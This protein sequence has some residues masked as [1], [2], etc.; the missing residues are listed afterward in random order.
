[1]RV[2]ETKVYSFDELNEEA[3]KVAVEKLHDINVQNDWYDYIFDDVRTFG[4]L[5]GIDINRIYFSGFWSQGDG[6]CF[7]CDYSYAK[8]SMSRIKEYAP[9]DEVLH[10]IAKRLLDVQKRNFYKLTATSKHRGHYYH[11]RCT[12]I[13]VYRD[14]NYI[15]GVDNSEEEVID[16][17]RDLMRWVYKQLEDAYDYATSESEII[18]TIKCNEYEFTSEGILI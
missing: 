16:S 15:N 3:K 13:Y 5:I 8:D 6:A 7:E 14:G 12:D 4:K 9:N 10:A 17:L 11:E 2:I 1:M 18:E